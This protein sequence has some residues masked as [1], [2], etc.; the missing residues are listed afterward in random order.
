[1]QSAIAG[2]VDTG[3]AGAERLSSLARAAGDRLMEGHA[4][5]FLAAAHQHASE[6]TRTL[7]ELDRAE[8]IYASIGASH[9]RRVTSNNRPAVLAH[10]LARAAAAE[11]ASKRGAVHARAALAIVESDPAG[12]ALAPEIL[13][14]CAAALGRAGD[15]TA[16]AHCRRRGREILTE[17]LRAI[18]SEDDRA[19]YLSLAWHSSLL[20][21]VGAPDGANG[22][23]EIDSGAGA[24]GAPRSPAPARAEAHG[25][26]ARRA[27]LT[28][29]PRP[30]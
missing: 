12:V 16:A 17:R 3:D 4:A 20:A 22:G 10:D 2:A 25:A 1:V 6:L 13:N 30:R 5:T 29:A 7:H 8:A 23:P 18:E 27:A 28:P 26:P 19:S 15:C 14:R 11:P 21:D 9:R 24:C